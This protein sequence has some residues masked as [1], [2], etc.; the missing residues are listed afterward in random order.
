VTTSPIISIRPAGRDDAIFGAEL[1]LRSRRASVPSIPPP[2]H[3]DEE[4]KQWVGRLVAANGV[5]VAEAEG[6]VV[7]VMALTDA[8]LDQLYVDPEWTG[9]GIGTRLVEYA[10]ERSPSLDLWTFQANIGARRFYERNGFV[11][12]AETEG[13]NEEG[14]PDVRYRWDSR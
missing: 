2:V 14:A 9:R 12:I 6:E 1:W 4:V 8:W 13:D 7:G 3:S 11:A 10:K 5:W